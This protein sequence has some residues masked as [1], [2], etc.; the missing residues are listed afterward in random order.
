MGLYYARE[1]RA[2][3]EV[4]RGADKTFTFRSDMPGVS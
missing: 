3:Y 1:D 4:I 2:F